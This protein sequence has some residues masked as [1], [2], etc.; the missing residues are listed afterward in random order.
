M[1]QRW[2]PSHHLQVLTFLP[3]GKQNF[4]F[5]FAFINNS[6]MKGNRFV[7]QDFFLFDFQTDAGICWS[8]ETQ[9]MILH[10]FAQKVTIFLVD[11]NEN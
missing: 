1:H 7:I 2:Y 4:F 6:G 9:R 10:L 8:K 3:H 5:V 11:V